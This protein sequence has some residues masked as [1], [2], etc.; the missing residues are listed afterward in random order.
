M[1]DSMSELIPVPRVR[2]IESISSKKTITGQ[3]SSLFSRARW[4][5][6]DEWGGLPMNDPATCET[7]LH[8]VLLDPI[9]VP[10]ERYFGWESRPA[11]TSTFASIR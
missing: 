3:P 2:N 4:I 11:A 10:P 6:L 9:G 1:V 8:E 7:F 5:K